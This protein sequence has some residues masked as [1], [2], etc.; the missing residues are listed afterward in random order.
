MH[1]EISLANTPNW[2]FDG[3]ST[4]QAEGTFSDLQLKPIYITL[5][6]SRTKNSYLVLCEVFN[7][8]GEP[9]STN[10]RAKLRQLMENDA[11]EQEPW[12]GFEQEYTLFKDSRPLGWPQKGYP[13]P[14]G[15][16]YC[17][18]G[19]EQVFGREI[20]EKHLSY[21]LEAGINICGINAEVMPGQWEYQIGPREKDNSE[22]NALNICD[23]AWIARWLLYKTCEEYSVEPNF[24]NKP[25]KGDWNGAGQHTN[26]STKKMRDPETGSA[27][28]ENAIER[29]AEKHE[30]HIRYYGSGLNERLTGLHETC[31]INEF[32]S[33]VSDRGASI[34][35]PLQV[36]K[37]GYGYIEDR[38]PGAN[39][40]PYQIARVLIETI[41]T[42]SSSS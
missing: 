2:G 27:S 11:K 5:D 18:L 25:V 17:E 34:R 16:F 8:D 14:Q 23:Q 7:A 33:G 26:F 36:S 24:S 30:D 39:A 1:E 13:A 31:A 21:C 35:I 29:L 37:Q 10:Q 9:H 28:I 42:K 38:R 19:S 20:A 22:Q 3:S 6:P 41:C 40:D 12:L 4:G 15:P 32:K